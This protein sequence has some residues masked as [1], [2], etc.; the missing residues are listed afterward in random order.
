MCTVA[1][2]ESEDGEKGPFGMPGHSG[3]VATRTN[4]VIKAGESLDIKVVYDPNA[5]GPAGVGSIIR[6]IYL[7]D[8]AGRILTLNIKA[9][10]TP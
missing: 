10:V 5:H 7:T 6:E 3:P 8:N 9:M 2:I 4:E 1:Y